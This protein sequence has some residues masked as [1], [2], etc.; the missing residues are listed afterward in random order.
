MCKCHSLLFIIIVIL[1]LSIK[2]CFLYLPVLAVKMDM[3][4]SV[5]I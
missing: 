2:F 3:L 1:T 4:T 5:D